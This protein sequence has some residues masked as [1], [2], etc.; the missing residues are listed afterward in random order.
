MH[1][2]HLP[3]GAKG[4]LVILLSIAV[5]LPLLALLPRYFAWKEQQA[6]ERAISESAVT[7]PVFSQ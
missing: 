2:H 5:I 6:T 1:I 3:R 4:P 7:A